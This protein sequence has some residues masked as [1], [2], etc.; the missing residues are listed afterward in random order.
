[1]RILPYSCMFCLRIEGFQLPSC[2]LIEEQILLSRVFLVDMEIFSYLKMSVT[3][4]ST[5]LNFCA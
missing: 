3:W 2:S 1:M 4:A 5:L